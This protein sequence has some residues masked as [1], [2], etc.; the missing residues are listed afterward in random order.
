DL[1]ADLFV[2]APRQIALRIWLRRGASISAKISWPRLQKLLFQRA[3]G[4]CRPH[5]GRLAPPRGRLMNQPRVRVVLLGSA[6]ALLL[7]PARTM[8]QDTLEREISVETSSTDP[9]LSPAIYPDFVRESLYLEMRDGV[10]LAADIF[11]PSRG[12]LATT[13]PL[14]VI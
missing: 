8:A 6:I 13:E 12:P 5:L 14:P 11:H 4:L 1:F 10:R 2:A 7:E 9:L 3:A